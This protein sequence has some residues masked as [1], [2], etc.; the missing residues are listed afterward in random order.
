MDRRGERAN[1]IKISY[2]PLNNNK[3]R[4]K[5]SALQWRDLDTRQILICRD[6]DDWQS[7]HSK[8]K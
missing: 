5:V 4:N 2:L 8:S 7:A 1:T 6:N 3:G